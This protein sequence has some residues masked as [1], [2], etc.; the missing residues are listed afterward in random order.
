MKKGERGVFSITN[1]K[2]DRLWGEEFDLLGNPG[3]GKRRG[4]KRFALEQG[5]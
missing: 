4:R 5:S 1:R 2:S 3:L